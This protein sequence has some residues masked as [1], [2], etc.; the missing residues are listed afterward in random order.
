MAK[1]IELTLKYG[2]LVPSVGL[3]KIVGGSTIDNSNDSFKFRISRIFRRGRWHPVR[4]FEVWIKENCVI[5]RSYVDPALVQ[6]R[7]AL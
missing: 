3:M 5:S 6:E 1:E 4:P 2:T 7:L